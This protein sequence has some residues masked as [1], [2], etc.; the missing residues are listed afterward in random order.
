MAN[1]KCLSGQESDP[2]VKIID[3]TDGEIPSY[4]VK[5][6]YEKNEKIVGCC[7]ADPRK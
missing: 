2:G 3:D 6:V 7:G 1:G 5:S 4:S